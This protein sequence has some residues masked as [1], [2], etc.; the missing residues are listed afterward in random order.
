MYIYRSNYLKAMLSVLRSG[1]SC[2]LLQNS[3]RFVQIGPEK[4]KD[5]R[6]REEKTWS[7]SLRAET[8]SC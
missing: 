8:G 2:K 6:K 7:N 1:I 3:K 5:D 4:Y